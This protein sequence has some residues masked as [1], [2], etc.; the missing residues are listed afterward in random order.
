M[1]RKSYEKLAKKLKSPP[2]GKIETIKKELNF[3]SKKDEEIK[4]LRKAHR[5]LRKMSNEELEMLSDSKDNFVLD[6]FLDQVP[7]VS[8]EKQ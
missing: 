2:E 3:L 4:E 8:I 5:Q 1:R 7:T 6:C